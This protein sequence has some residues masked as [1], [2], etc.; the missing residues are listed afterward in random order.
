MPNF[1]VVI[2]KAW[3]LTP[4]FFVLATVCALTRREPDCKKVEYWIVKG[5]R[6]KII[7]K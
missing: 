7:P 3:W 6:P 1:T 4:Y 5:M 2:K